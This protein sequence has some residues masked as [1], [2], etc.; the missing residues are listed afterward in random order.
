MSS[1]S[2]NVVFFDLP[3]KQGISWSL[4]PWKT[5]MVLNYKKIPYTTEWVEYPD[6]A[7]KFKALGIPPNPKDAPGYFT[8]YSSPAIKYADGNYG[9]DSW[10]IAHS[11]EK[12]YPSPSLHLDDPIVVKIRDH[13]S[14]MMWPLV[15]LLMPRVPVVLLNKPSADYFFESR[16]KIFGKP[17]EEMEKGADVE[18]CWEGAR[19]PAKEV[20]DLLRKNGG[21]FFLGET[22]SYADLIFV[23][24]LQFL[25]C[26]NE[27][28]FKRFLAMDDTFPKIYDASKQWLEKQD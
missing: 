19:A 23:S 24:M 8:D 2:S 9:M 4:N 3:S 26:I 5:R 1:S 17:L 21:P 7:P 10:P 15:P 11:L 18:Q 20:G 16:A 27:D 6:L 14:V 22:V 13:M 25:Q 28:T 12:Q